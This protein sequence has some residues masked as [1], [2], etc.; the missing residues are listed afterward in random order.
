MSANY[1]PDTFTPL[2]HML[3]H[4]PATKRWLVIAQA[5]E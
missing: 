2:R 1:S 3:L 5:Q 4:K